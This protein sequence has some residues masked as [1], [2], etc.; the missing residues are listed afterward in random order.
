MQAVGLVDWDYL[1]PAPR[2]DD[3]AYALVWF[4]PLRS[5]EMALE[6]HHFPQV[7]D[8]PARVRAF[9][10][11]Y[12]PGSLR[13]EDVVEEVVASVAR[14]ASLELDLARRGVEPQR[15]WVADGSQEAA[16]AE[17]RWLRDNRER[18]VGSQP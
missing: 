1:H 12:G 16:A 8:R 13:V 9:L 11:A 2:T 3:L 6:W 4:A 14:T 10:D 18:L 15:S 5:D 7:P 17:I